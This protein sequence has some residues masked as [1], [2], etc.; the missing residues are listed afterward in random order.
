MATSKAQRRLLAALDRLT[1]TVRRRVLKALEA[2][3]AT[4][5]LD[6]ILAA[7][8]QA[9]QLALNRLTRSLS[10]SL[11]GA[12]ATVEQAYRV[13]HVAG[14]VTA[15]LRLMNPSAVQA[16]A[17]AGRLVTGI[18]TETRRGIQ[19]IVESSV[20]DGLAPREAAKRL[21]SL[22][23]LTERQA[24]AVLAQ[25]AADAA[26][27][28]TAD[29][30]EARAQRYADRLLRQRAELIARTEILRAANEGQLDLW[31]QAQADGLLPRDARKQWVVTPDDRLCPFC[32][33]L[34]GD[35]Q[36]LEGRFV[37]GRYLVEAP[38]L[39]PQCRC[40]LVMASRA[41][42]ARRAA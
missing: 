31:R 9:D 34:D 12:V 38:P 26:A 28:R 35:T 23:G 27:G 1:P 30:I 18:T 15:S 11:R 39:H 25:R 16:S 42:A 19:A 10:R 2:L 33:P 21:R 7:L 5:S 17:S 24:Q 13:G 40:T 20:R 41:V 22:I 37:S 14:R 29:A 4:T 32:E 6:A 3:R 8:E 36:P